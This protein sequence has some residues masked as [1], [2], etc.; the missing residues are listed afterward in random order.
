MINEGGDLIIESFESLIIII[1]F[2]A[3]GFILFYVRGSFTPRKNYETTTFILQYVFYSLILYFMCLPIIYLCIKSNYHIE[4]PIRTITI[5]SS[6]III[7][8]IVLG[9]VI[10]IVEQKGLDKK[11]LNKLGI[12]IIHSTPTAWDYK[13]SNIKD[14]SWI[15]VTTKD[16][17]K[18]M[19]YFS[20]QSFASSEAE[21][22]DLYLEKLYTRNEDNTDW[23]LN[24][25][26]DGILIKV[27][28]IKYLEFIR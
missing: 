14:Y 7:I 27:E 10:G 25:Q 26:N 16:D 24:G 1:G 13:F 17:K 12:S 5:F 18:F 4:H 23:I 21:E 15:I 19:G 11:V 8:P 9:I 28:E 22:R 20:T 3:P 6:L 2:L